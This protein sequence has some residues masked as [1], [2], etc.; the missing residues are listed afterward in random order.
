MAVST[1]VVAGCASGDTGT[2]PEAPGADVDIAL[3][4]EDFAAAAGPDEVFELL[5][6]LEPL[7]AAGEG[8]IA[9]LLPDTQSSA[10]YVEQDT[11]A[12]ERA[13][14]TMGLT[15]D[16]YIILN[17][18]NSPQTQQTQAEQ[19]ISN[20]AS[21]LLLDNLDSGSGAAIQ[22]NAAAAGVPTIDYDRLT[23]NGSAEYYVSFDNE[24]VG[25]ALA[26]GVV[27]CIDDWSVTDPNLYILAGSPT[28]NNATLSQ[29]GIDDVIDPLVD[30]G[31][32]NLVSAVRVPNW[33]NQVGQTMF[34]Q[35]LTANPEINAVLTGNDGL[36]QS[37][38]SVLKN[39]GVQ[40]FSVPTTGQDA[41]LQG[42]QNILA[43]YQCMSVYKQ[44]YI[45]AAAAAALAVIVRAGAEPPTGLINGEYD[46][47][48]K[49]VP[50]LL[51]RPIS[52]DATN[53]QDTVIAD[54]VIDPAE[55]CTGEF[56]AK[57]E[58]H[59]IG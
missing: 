37:A 16:D 44:V 52:V 39:Q 11:P 27:K 4:A 22:A 9:V 55:L 25:T 14:E 6:Q 36:A 48:S 2:G 49:M 19:A 54:G 33:D 29:Q 56:A 51:L 30:S 1:L 34:E 21:V 18:Q 47:E 24:Y 3:S 23:L 42:M 5:R 35:A 45:E 7:A 20:G 26:E 31:E 38:I 58:E 43:G 59:G 17:A 32:L 40:P 57:C 8:K 10:R 41:T 12:F 15:E 28:D 50:S 13:F 46:A 53:M